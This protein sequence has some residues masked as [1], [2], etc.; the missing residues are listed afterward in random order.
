MQKITF[1]ERQFVTAYMDASLA[2][3]K[4]VLMEQNPDHP[5][6]GN[7]LQNIKNVMTCFPFVFG[8]LSQQEQD[9]FMF[10]DGQTLTQKMTEFLRLVDL[11]KYHDL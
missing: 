1:E 9:D 6:Y 4:R 10:T 11:I 5:T 8:R 3:A 7:H 2:L